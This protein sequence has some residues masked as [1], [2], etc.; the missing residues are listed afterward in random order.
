MVSV[1]YDRLKDI[2]SRNKIVKETNDLK[3]KRVFLLSVKRFMPVYSRQ[4]VSTKIFESHVTVF[5]VGIQ[6]EDVFIDFY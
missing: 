4:R 1:I 5:P 3:A 2:L 6:S